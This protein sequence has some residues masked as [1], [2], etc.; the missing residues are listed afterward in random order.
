MSEAARKAKAAAAKDAED[1]VPKTASKKGPAAS[2]T[3]TPN[4]HDLTEATMREGWGSP[5]VDLRS[6]RT[7]DGLSGIEAGGENL[8]QVSED[9]HE[10]K[11]E[12]EPVPPPKRSAR[13][14]R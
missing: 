14:R 2:S 5:A 8:S 4:P 12:Q 1:A 11:E 10:E 13:T 6:A 9:A 7:V 3:A